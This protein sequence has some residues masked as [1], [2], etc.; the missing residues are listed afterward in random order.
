MYLV[1]SKVGQFVVFSLCMEAREGMSG[2]TVIRAEAPSAYHVAPRTENPSQI[3]GSPTVAASS[4]SVALTGPT[5]KKKRGRPRKYGPD[6]TVAMALS[7]MPISSSAPPSGHSF[8]GKRGRGKHSGYESRLFKRMGKDN[9]GNKLFSSC[10]SCLI[11][12]M[13]FS[14]SLRSVLLIYFCI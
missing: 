7:P 10:L 1:L 11:S 9:F 6:G 3:D 14:L 8:P 5:E 13:V 4:V 2:V 12:S